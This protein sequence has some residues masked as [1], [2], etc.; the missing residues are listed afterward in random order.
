MTK[1]LFLCEKG[2]LM[3][4]IKG[5]A[6]QLPQFKDSD[7][8]ALYGHITTA[9]G[10][11]ELDS[12]WKQW[13][14]ENL[15]ILVDKLE[16]TPKIN[17]D[18]GE[19]NEIF[20]NIERLVS[21]NNYDFIINACDPE[22]EGQVIFQNVYDLLNINT[23]IKRFWTNDLTEESI[24][25]ALLNLRDDKDGKKPN[26]NYLTQEALLRQLF[27]Y[28]FGMSGTRAAS[29]KRGVI[30]HVGRVK[31]AVEKIVVDR[32]L[33][34][35][36]FVPKTS[37]GL[38]AIFDGFEGDF[39][40]VINNKDGAKTYEYPLWDTE[41]EAIEFSK[42]FSNPLK[43]I[44]IDSTK[45]KETAPALYITS[46]I[47][48]DASK[49]YGYSI[50]DTLSLLQSLYEKEIISY[51]RTDNNCI[52][53]ELCSEFP[54]ILGALEAIPEYEK[55]AKKYKNDFK[56][57]ELVKNTKK[58]VNDKKMAEAGHYAI[59][60]TGKSINYDYLSK[61]EQNI[62]KLIAA[63]TLSIFAPPMVY[64]TKEVLFK[65]KNDYKFKA[66]GRRL[67]QQGYYE[68]I[69]KEFFEK[70]LPNLKEE[71][72][73]PYINIGTYESTTTPPERFTDG[74]LVKS[75]MA[76]P[77]PFLKDMSWRSTIR[78]VKGIGT[79]AT[80]T[81]IVSDLIEQGYF[82]LKA[83]RGKAKQI[84]AT[85]KAI[86]IIQELGNTVISSVD[87][88]AMWENNLAKVER[89]ELS[90]KD[91]KK[92]MNEFITS[93]VEEIKNS[94]IQ[95]AE[96]HSGSKL[97]TIG[98]CPAC[99]GNVVAGN[100]Y[101][102]CENYRKEKDCKF[103]LGKDTR[104]ASISEADVKKILE[105]KTTKKLKMK[106]KDG[107]EF[108]AALKWNPEEN[109]IVFA[110][111]DKNEKKTKFKC[112]ICSQDDLV[113]TTGK[114]G[115]YFKCPSCGFI[116]SETINKHKLSQMEIKKIISGNKTEPIEF[117]K[118]DGLGTY[119]ASLYLDKFDKKIKYEFEKKER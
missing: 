9:K 84:Y 19:V 3:Q 74:T 101:Y 23:P 69:D 72:E 67:V 103:I 73:I 62:L 109:K 5:V 65:D 32:E 61:S 57:H 52:S 118:K 99:G 41:K 75:V 2:T 104:G 112:P 77:A 85:D 76:N 55:Y 29:V 107:K 56:A 71:Q 43:V 31:L 89:G 49:V 108:E 44:S 1:Y 68:I 93:A 80:R 8:I 82:E 51:P 36:N 18:T 34:I 20:K 10:P 92:E 53:S 45:R 11:D 39:V 83:G 37:Y 96:R 33:A 88:T 42:K 24:K 114:Y 111:Q 25:K 119:K 110:F 26:L 17:K 28:C 106:N 13:S 64:E 115:P 90:S 113:K 16:F 70:E 14:F 98:K 60:P 87:M 40:E 30:T 27:D 4:K 47:Q 105:G 22:R 97:E 50:A 94:N 12:K 100:K 79:E 35:R 66:N 6:M 21:V 78:E 7:Y 38:E 81:K 48:A 54:K 91:F 95:K 86:Q 46:E 15:P 58:Y 102:F 116:L 59:I 63:R 117:T